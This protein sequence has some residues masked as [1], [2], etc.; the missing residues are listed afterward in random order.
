MKIERTEYNKHLTDFML[1]YGLTF[2]I[3]NNQRIILITLLCNITQN[4]RKKDPKVL[5]IDLI[6][7][8]IKNETGSALD[9]FLVKASYQCEALLSG[10]QAQFA[11]FGLKETKEKVDKIRKIAD[12]F[13]PF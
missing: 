8:I 5:V 10:D 13:L 6:E 3:D 4:L 12:N 7:K 1:N 2:G 9:E 11:D